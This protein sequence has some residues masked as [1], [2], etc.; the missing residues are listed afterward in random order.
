M[1]DRVSAYQP[2][3]LSVLRIISGLLFLQHGTA[4]VLGFPVVEGVPPPGLSL[5]GLSGPLELVFGVLLVL[6][7]FTRPVAFLASGLCAVGYWMVHAAGGAFPILNGGE[8]I[9]LYCF[10]F[11]YLCAAGPGPWSVDAAMGKRA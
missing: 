11:L 3:L 2:Q 9:A 5:A 8:L 6:G 1:F 4:K 7:L 10:V